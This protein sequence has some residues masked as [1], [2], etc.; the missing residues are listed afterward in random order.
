MI[1]ALGRVNQRLKAAGTDKTILACIV[2]RK[3]YW[4]INPDELSNIA[5]MEEIR[6]V[7]ENIQKQIGERLFHEAASGRI[8]NLEDLVDD[9]WW[10]RLKRSMFAWKTK[11]LPGIVTHNLHD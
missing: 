7:C 5:M 6:R 4:T 3:P 9:Y 2:T 11:R 1:D 10:L 8:P